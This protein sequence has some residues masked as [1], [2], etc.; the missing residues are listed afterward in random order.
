MTLPAR[1]KSQ[2]GLGGRGYA[3]FGYPQPVLP[4]VTTILKNEAKPALT[5]WAAD[6]TAAY[7]VA[8]ADQLYRMSDQRGW[9]FLR[10]LWN[11][12]PKDPL[13]TETDLA[14]YHATVLS[15]AGELGD[16][17]HEWI[18]ADLSGV[19]EYPN[20][21]DRNETFWKCGAAGNE[22]K[23]EHH[24]A[25]HRT[26][27]TVWNGPEEGVGYAGTFDLMMEVDGKLYLV[28]IKT[29]RGLY[30]STWMQLSALYSAKHLLELGPD[31]KDQM[32]EGWQLPIEGVAVLHVRP[33]DTTWD[34]RPMAPFCKWVELPTEKDKTFL[35]SV[36]LFFRGFMS[37]RTYAEA[38][39]EWKGLLK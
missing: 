1:A 34:G 11:R 31:G 30:S 38:A 28:D 8:N 14:G 18:E 13:S 33:S 32:I 23:A 22:W 2:S 6:Q 4:S 35:D 21:T 37:L 17:V 20:L 3:R 15:D 25:F 26:G 36:A 5:Q 12:S 19:T 27:I 39:R 10:Y 7:A 24:V 16:S 29:S 9:G